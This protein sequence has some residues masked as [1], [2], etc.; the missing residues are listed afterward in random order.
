M[1]EIVVFLVQSDTMKLESLAC[2]FR[3]EGFVERERLR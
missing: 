3:C 1:I 2:W